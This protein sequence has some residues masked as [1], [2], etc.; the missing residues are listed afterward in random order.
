MIGLPIFSQK[1]LMV[2]IGSVHTSHNVLDPATINAFFR[3]YS[4]YVGKGRGG[5]KSR[6]PLAP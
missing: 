6:I 2:L 4:I 5:T 1:G 3:P